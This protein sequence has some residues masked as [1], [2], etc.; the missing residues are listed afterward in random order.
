MPGLMTETMT[1]YTVLEDA[2]AHLEK[3]VSD[4]QS[5]MHT[6]VVSTGDGDLRVMVLRSIDR[7]RRQLRF[8]T[9]ARAPKVGKIEHDPEVGLLFYDKEAKLQLRCRG[10]GQI[11]RDGPQSED[12]W[13]QSTNFAKRCYLAPQAPSSI[14]DGPTANLPKDLEGVAPSDER[15]AEGRDNFAVLLVTLKSLDWFHLAHDGHRRARFTWDDEDGVKA[16]WLAP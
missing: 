10:R 11:E 13:Q 4:R 3:A 1:L 2:F 7:E 12:A 5:M 15:A 6:P 8:H 9:D 14:A 16:H